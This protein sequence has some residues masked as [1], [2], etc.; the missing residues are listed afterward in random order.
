MAPTEA[1]WLIDFK[2]RNTLY[3]DSKTLTHADVEHLYSLC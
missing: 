3:G 2:K 1:F